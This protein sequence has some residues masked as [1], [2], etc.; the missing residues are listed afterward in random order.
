MF[1]GKAPL[2]IWLIYKRLLTSELFEELLGRPAMQQLPH[3]HRLTACWRG[4]SRGLARIDLARIDLARIDLARVAGD[5]SIHTKAMRVTNHGVFS[6]VIRLVVLSAL[7]LS[8]SL[9]L[10]PFAGY[11]A[12]ETPVPVAKPPN[13][14]LILADDLGYSDLGAYGSEINT[15]HIDALA[16][17]GVRFSNFHTAASC[18]PT[19]AMLLTGLESHL[20]GVANIPEAIP[21]YQR[22]APGYAGVLRSDVPTLAELLQSAGYQ[23]FMS[24]KWHLGAAPQ[25]LPSQRGFIKTFALADTGADNWRQQPYL[26]IYAEAN[27]FENGERTDLPDDFY[28]SKTIVDKALEHLASRDLDKPFFSYLA[29]Q[30]VHIPVQAPAAFRDRYLQHYND[31]WTALKQARADGLVRA[32]I[33]LPA[34]FTHAP[35]TADWDALSEAEQAFHSRGMAVYAGMVDAMDHHIGRLVAYL[36]AQGELDN[37]ILVFLSD[38]GAEGS[39]IS[40]TRPGGPGF[41]SAW[42]R[43]WLA[44]NSYTT[45][46]ESLGEKGSFYEIGPSWASASVGPLAWYKFFAGEGGLRVPLIISGRIRGQPIATSGA[47]AGALTW[48]TD[49]APTLLD[50]VGAPNNDVDF[51]GYSL[52][53]LLTNTDA[54]LRGPKEVVGYELGGNRALYQGPYKIVYNRFDAATDQWQL[55]DLA[56]D[57]GETQDLAEAMPDRTAVMIAAYDRWADEHGVLPVAD[58]YNQG[59]QV[60]LNGFAQRPVLWLPFVLVGVLIV[61]VLL[62]FLVFLWRLIRRRAPA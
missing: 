8:L 46:P 44:L 20:A 30:A 3:L 16:N 32:G 52:T 28:S 60:M 4:T 58:D 54:S 62:V 15:P 37:T 17:A 14:V 7:S 22:S 12:A 51:S 9:S 21:D 41:T 43:S 26:P 1:V 34:A 45:E 59:M 35:T 56:N 47:V 39:V 24:G 25:Q 50:L 61:V 2:F 31:G 53:P 5:R 29:F 13:I 42:F 10:F 33:M 6:R 57:P 38:N 36:Q 23:S 40:R 11:A 49:I 48:V 19:R 55:Y 27:W 18:A